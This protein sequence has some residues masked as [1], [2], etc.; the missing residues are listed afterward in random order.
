MTLAT[1]H[2]VA[3]TNPNIGLLIAGMAGLFLPMI[4]AAFLAA[5]LV[6]AMLCRYR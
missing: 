4:A 2:R 1:F 6:A 5:F 3:F